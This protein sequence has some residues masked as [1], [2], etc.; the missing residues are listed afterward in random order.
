MG[1][2]E[3]ILIGA[4]C[5]DYVHGGGTCTSDSDCGNG[6]CLDGSCM[7]NS[8]YV[9]S[10]CSSLASDIVAGSSEQDQT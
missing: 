7:C 1:L 6:V 8:G 3:D 2:N 4:T 5:G 9:C 10:Y